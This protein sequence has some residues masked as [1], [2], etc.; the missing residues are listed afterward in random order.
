M[1]DGIGV[2]AAAAVAAGVAAVAL[3]AAG[4]A[5]GAVVGAAATE[6]A[7]GL[8]TGADV[9]AAG[10]PPH[11][12]RKI[13]IVAVPSARNPRRETRPGPI[14]GPSL[15]ASARHHRWLAVL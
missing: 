7:V 3:V 15:L 10:A 1:A 11:A 2:V 5:V 4:A 14:I 9:G 8:A 12:A 6:A 13:P